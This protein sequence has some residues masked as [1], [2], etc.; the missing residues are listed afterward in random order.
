MAHDADHVT[1]K[2]KGL[3]FVEARNEFVDDVLQILVQTHGGTGFGLIERSLAH[4]TVGPGVGEFGL[5]DVLQEAG[6]AE[7]VQGRAVDQSR[8]IDQVATAQEA[9]DP[10]VQVDEA[11]SFHSLL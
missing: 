8:G 3:T 1:R 11:R 7:E 4:G 6:A 2:T 10:L 9:R 5:A